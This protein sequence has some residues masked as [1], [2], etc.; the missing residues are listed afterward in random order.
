MKTDLELAQAVARLRTTEDW[1][2]VMDRMEAYLERLKNDMMDVPPEDVIRV[3]G[4]AKGVSLLNK[5][6]T[7]ET[8][9]LLKR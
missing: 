6:L 3:A 9:K 4:M 7:I 5:A 2:L 8:D 1:L